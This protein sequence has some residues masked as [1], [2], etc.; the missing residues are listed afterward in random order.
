MSKLHRS[1]RRLAPAVPSRRTFLR[2]AGATLALPF[3]GSL[4][5]GQARANTGGIKRLLYFFL[6]NGINMPEWTPAQEGTSYTLSATLQPLAPFQSQ[7]TVVSG[8]S[9]YGAID[10]GEGHEP[11]TAAFLTCA[12]PDPDV[13]HNGISVDQI[14]ANS[15]TGVTPFASLEIGVEAG[16]GVGSCGGDTCAYGRNISWADATTPRPKV[17][18]PS[19]LFERMFGGNSGNL[20][21][22]E[23]ER[24]KTLR[25]SVLDKVATHAETLDA[26]LGAAD[27]Q[28]LDAYLTGVRDL[29]LQVESL[30]LSSC[31][32]PDAPGTDL[33]YP[34]TVQTYIDLMVKTFE[35]DLTRVQ[36]FM[37]GN[38]ATNRAYPH[39]G[40]PDSHHALSHHGNDSATRALL[41]QID[42][43]EMEQIAYLLTQLQNTPS[44]T[45]GT[46]LDET[47]VFVSSELSCGHYHDNFD[48]PVVIAGGGAA[49]QHGQHLRVQDGALADLH[50]ALLEGFGVVENTL[51]YVG[52]GP[53][54]GILAP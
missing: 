54:P 39:I 44:S 47:I 27:R 40:I 2:G 31:D 1:F 18:S 5:P 6:P 34:Q 3:L 46:L 24:R 33:E 28:K 30:S 23:A 19:A 22:A 9:N 10:G 14:A 17:S 20:T 51:G 15:L 48:L 53:L 41:T 26:Q 21:P 4:A 36:S 43:W 35:C 37:L 52:A 49:F 50:L 16:S 32:P 42:I 45:G 8:L 13:V 7:M 12:S 25:L 11:G 29:E 38:A